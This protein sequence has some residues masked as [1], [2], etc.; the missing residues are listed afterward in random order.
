MIRRVW[1][2]KSK[3]VWLYLTFCLPMTPIHDTVRK[4]SE[5]WPIPQEWD[6]SYIWEFWGLLPWYAFKW[7]DFWD[8]WIPIIKIKNISE[9]W[10]VDLQDTDKVQESV[11]NDKTSKFLLWN[12]D[13]IVAMTWATIGKVWKIKSHWEKVLLNQRVG[14]F[15]IKNF[16][17]L[18]KDFLYY[19][20]QNKPFWDVINNVAN[21]VAQANISWLQIENIPFPLPPLPEQQA[22]ASILWSLDDKIELLREQNRTLEQIGQTMFRE[23]FGK[24]KMEDELP[25]GWRVGKLGEEFDIIMWQSPDGKSYNE[26][27]EGIVFFQ[28]RAEFQERFPKIRLYTTESSRIAEKND[29][30]VSVR[31]PV[32][33]INIA[34]EKCCIGR[35]LSAIKSKYKSYCLYKMQSLK[36]VF[37][38]FNWESNLLLILVIVYCR[39]WWVEGWECFSFLS[40]YK[41]WQ[42]LICKKLPQRK[43]QQPR[44]KH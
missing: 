39:G 19:S 34:I 18:D 2:K 10:N 13:F 27:W 33:D 20:T 1:N 42:N 11:L 32:W 4:D 21:W 37:D 29:I 16:K 6:V 9:T 12:W 8:E 23:W 41:S 3:K 43:R 38:Q 5:L 28:G 7:E 14:K 24:Y 36:D 22:I 26:H 40:Y 30:L 15:E 31:A 44:V 25:E 17:K 35:W